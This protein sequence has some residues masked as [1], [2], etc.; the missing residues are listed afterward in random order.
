MKKGADKEDIL[1]RLVKE[2]K[3]IKK[4]LALVS[5]VIRSK[6]TPGKGIS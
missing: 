2:F 1:E 3:D 6:N 5:Y 4:D